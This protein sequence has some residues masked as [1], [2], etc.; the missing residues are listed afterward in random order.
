MPR[1]WELGDRTYIRFA[2]NFGF[3][4]PWFGGKRIRFARHHGLQLV[5]WIGHRWYVEK[6]ILGRSSVRGEEHI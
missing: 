3:G 2:P 6:Q 5:K 4:I 1:I